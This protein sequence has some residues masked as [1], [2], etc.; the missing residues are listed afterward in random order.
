[1]THS[2]A[3][4]SRLLYK[5]DP[6]STVILLLLSLLGSALD[7][8]TVFS[9][10]FFFANEAV[11]SSGY[12]YLLGV[13]SLVILI[14]AARVFCLRYVSDMGAIISSKLTTLLYC[15]YLK[16]D[17][18]SAIAIPSAKFV[19]LV[20]KQSS[21]ILLAV[22]APLCSI[23]VS[24]L[25]FAAIA[26]F[27][28]IR[29]PPFILFLALIAAFYVLLLFALKSSIKFM[30][31]KYPAL[32][33]TQYRLLNDTIYSLPFIFSSSSQGEFIKNFSNVDLQVKSIGSRL[34]FL[35]FSPRFVLE[36]L[37]V[38]SLILFFSSPSLD[39][40]SLAILSFSVLRIVPSI[41]TLYSA[42]LSIK[43]NSLAFF[44][45]FNLTH[46]L[47]LNSFTVTPG[48]L[49]AEVSHSFSVS[50][51]AYSFPDK[52]FLI[53]DIV[54]NSGLVNQDLPLRSTR[55][56]FPSLNVCLGS[57]TAIVG[58][59]GSGKSTFLELL[60]GLR[61]FDC[62]TFQLDF[63]RIN[64]SLTELSFPP[65]FLFYMPQYTHLLSCT[66]LDNIVYPRSSKHLSTDDLSLIEL[67]MGLPLSDLKTIH[68]NPSSSLLSG[69]QKQRLGFLRALLSGA[70]FLL[71]DEPTSAQDSVNELIMLNYLRSIKNDKLILMTAHREQPMAMS[72]AIFTFDL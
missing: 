5:F 61:N 69:G 35:S 44:E 22:I 57:I 9:L 31:Q 47:S 3:S 24:F 65:G 18:E 50:P 11:K 4:I 16:L 8:L 68:L 26:A 17:Y 37:L 40:S 27:L 36:C 32:V 13:C 56:L 55:L 28:L 10:Q 66:L 58:S 1:M 6:R 59:S 15:S 51:S 25:S 12:S 52:A 43:A 23:P 7:L 62:G 21:D 72:D 19:S 64:Q 20:A 42:Y 45:V 41:N 29:Y 14:Y 48:K 38:L 33:E 70:K 60:S 49:F 67:I 34:Q 39:N 63:S 53:R 30:N 54:V 2:I 46:A 71:L